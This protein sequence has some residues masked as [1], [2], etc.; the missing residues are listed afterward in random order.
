MCKITA[1][2]RTQSVF[3]IAVLSTLP[4]AH[5]QRQTRSHTH[6][7]QCNPKRGTEA[8]AKAKQ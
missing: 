1:H 3:R 5:A 4:M 6:R 2:T 8:E 7:V